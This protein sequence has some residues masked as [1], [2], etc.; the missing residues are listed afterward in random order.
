MSLILIVVRL[1]SIKRNLRNS[2]SFHKF[3]PFLQISVKQTQSWEMARQRLLLYDNTN[4]LFDG[5][6][7]L[8]F[9]VTRL[10]KI[11]NSK[12]AKKSLS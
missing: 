1:V 8:R 7:I 6:R 9:S 3:C 2:L 10:V 11:I 4:Q 5:M 12:E